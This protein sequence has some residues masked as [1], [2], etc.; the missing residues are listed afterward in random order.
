MPDEARDVVAGRVRELLASERIVI[1]RQ[2]K[3]GSRKVLR[4]LDIRPMIRSLAMRDE[5]VVA[6]D[7]EFANVGT[8]P[9]KAKDLVPMLASAGNERLV[10]ILKR[11]TVFLDESQW[12][13]AGHVAD[14]DD[15]ADAVDV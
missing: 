6:V 5:A 8:K 1:R 7:A 2:A 10:R 3:D 15:A 9:G 11:E 4:D 13:R 12:H 14:D